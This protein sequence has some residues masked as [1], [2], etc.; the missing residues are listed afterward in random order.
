MTKRN[1]FKRAFRL[2]ESNCTIISDKESAVEKA[3]SS[4]RHHRGQL[5]EYIRGHPRFL[6]SL[7]PLSVDSGPEV[8]RLMAE[9]SAKAAVGPMAAVA[10]VLADLAVEE[11][12]RDGCRVAVVENGGEVSAVS[13][14]PV[15]IALAA[16]DAPL[17]RE[18]GFR[19]KKFPVGVAT[20]SGL[21]SHAFSFG[22]A[23]AVTVFA[24]DAGVADAAA[25]A[26]ANLIKGDDVRGVIRQGI[27]RA[28][29]IDGVQ[30]IFILYRGVVGKA[31]QVP[32]LIK[33]N[34]KE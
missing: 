34:P 9:A 2:K 31:G 21:Y 13:D 15:D 8:A 18:M 33:V 7:E 14:Q 10:G 30:G 1:L 26:V 5:E 3:V 19:L 23:E 32:E 25:T 4:I 6:H 28:L 11:M 24:V 27:D 16:G 20:S 22:E 17:S 29:S 12:L